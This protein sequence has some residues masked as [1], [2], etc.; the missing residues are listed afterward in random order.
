M[1]IN[2]KIEQ[3][4]EGFLF[5]AITPNGRTLDERVHDARCVLPCAEMKEP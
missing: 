3:I 1:A 5:Y 4:E 2:T